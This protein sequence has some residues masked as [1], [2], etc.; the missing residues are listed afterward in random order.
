MPALAGSG[1]DGPVIFVVPQLLAQHR[2]GFLCRAHVPETLVKRR[3][4]DQVVF[5]V[6]GALASITIT[7]L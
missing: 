6:A 1:Q 2:D 7:T 4:A 5:V 3:Q